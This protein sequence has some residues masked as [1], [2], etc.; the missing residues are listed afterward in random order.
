MFVERM[1][2]TAR[3]RLV[4]ILHS[5]PLIEAARL[6]AVRELLDAIANLP[7]ALREQDDLQ[8]RINSMETDRKAFAEAVTQLRDAVGD[9]FEGSNPLIAGSG[10]GSGQRKPPP[11]SSYPHSRSALQIAR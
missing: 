8:H 6:G 4:T 5:A 11:V 7:E 1:V 2:T 10:P 9:T 3:E